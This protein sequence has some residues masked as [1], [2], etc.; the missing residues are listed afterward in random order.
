MRPTMMNNTD[1]QVPRADNP[2]SKEPSQPIARSVLYD[3]TALLHDSTNQYIYSH[4]KI[5]NVYVRA[6][7]YRKS[8]CGEWV[9]NSMEQ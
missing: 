3:V 7:K 5:I 4:F 8:H 6:S 1:R 2:E 9:L